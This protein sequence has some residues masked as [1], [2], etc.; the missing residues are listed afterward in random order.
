MQRRLRT[1][2]AKLAVSLFSFVLAL[3]VVEAV[4]RVMGIRGEFHRPP[5]EQE[6]YP[7]GGSATAAPHGDIPFGLI[8][9]AYDSDPRGYFDPGNV[10]DHVLNSHGW[11]DDEHPIEKPPRTY[12]ILGLGD[13]YL[14]GQGVKRRD[15]CLTR[16]GELLANDGPAK[17]IEVINTGTVAKNT[18][19][20]RD[21]LLDVG[22]R[23]D[24]DLVILHFCP[25][26]VEE[27]VMRWGPKIEFFREY[28]AI[29]QIPD[30]FS[31]Y[32]HF[33]GWARQQ[34]RRRVMGRA[35]IRECLASFH[36]EG[37][38]WK[39]CQKALADIQRI[40]T[41]RDVGLLVVI[42]PFFH[43]LDG[44]YPFQPVHDLVRGLCQ[45]SGIH[46]LD[47]RGHYREFRGP[48]L[49]VHPTDQHPNEIAHGIAARA[50]AE[51]LRTHPDVYANHSTGSSQTCDAGFR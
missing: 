29:Y 41:E 34:Y 3:L 49:W 40:C 9:I 11:R 43:E 2:R 25:N 46:V 20:E 17:Q 28:T 31:K 45:S 23:Y 6:F 32:S 33:W 5:I 39:R 38:P 4:F 15:I 14:Y 22:L 7:V 30:A 36:E 42:L 51:Y 35:Y 18:V 37:R 44:D 21:L 27:D 24:P 8:R 50:M 16:L 13:S 26:D 10:V 47:L 1:L 19:D 48:E 12:R